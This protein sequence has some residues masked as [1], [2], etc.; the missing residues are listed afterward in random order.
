MMMIFGGLTGACWASFLL[1]QTW[2]S[3]QN[4]PQ[5][6]RSYCP[7]CRGPIAGYDN[8]P[9]LSFLILRGRCRQCRAAIDPLGWYGE[10]A[11]LVDG[12]LV[13]RQPP[14]VITFAVLLSILAA[15]DLYR[16]SFT[17]GWFWLGAAVCLVCDWRSLHWLPALL[18]FGAGILPVRHH[19][20]GDG[21]SEVITLAALLFGLISVLVWLLIASGLGIVLILMRRGDRRQPLPF[22]P[23]LLVALLVLL[24]I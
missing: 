11:G 7:A 17:D 5:P 10:I 6:A 22:L 16:Y 19:Q 20:L 9:V 24:S 8:I 2:R 18:V 14:S 23:V 15:S 12:S 1:C 3:T 13:I 21:D 4:G